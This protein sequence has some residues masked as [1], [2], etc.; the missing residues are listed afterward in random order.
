[1]GGK[2]MHFWES[3]ADDGTGKT[4]CG[5]SKR[6]TSQTWKQTSKRCPK[7]S[8]KKLG[9]EMVG[10]TVTLELRNRQTV[11]V[12]N[13]SADDYRMNHMRQRGWMP[14][15]ELCCRLGIALIGTETTD[16]KIV[17]VNHE[18]Q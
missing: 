18:Q 3:I 8:K 2:V 11:Q 5:E 7:C 9:C 15:G 12:V 4:A 14:S 16:L 6:I 13:K 17:E 1:M 10:S